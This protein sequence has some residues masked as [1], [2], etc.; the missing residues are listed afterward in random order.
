M[1]KNL[2]TTVPIPLALALLLTCF[3]LFIFRPSGWTQKNGNI[4]Y[5]LK[6]GH[7]AIGWQTIENQ[8]YCFGPDGALLTGWQ[9]IEYKKYYLHPDGTPTTGWLTDQD[10]RRYFDENGAMLVG[11]HT[12]DGETHHFAPDGIEVYLVNPWNKLPKDYTVELTSLSH[13]HQIATLCYDDLKQMFADCK[14]AG[15]SPAICSSYRSQ[16]KQEALFQRKMEQYLRQ[17]HSQQEAAQLAGKVVAVPGTSEHQLGLA[18]DIVDQQNW[19]L[20]QSQENTPTQRWLLENSWKYGFILRYPNAK[21]QIT[22]I[23]Y[24]PW[25]YRYVGRKIAAEIHDSGLCLEEYLGAATA[26]SKP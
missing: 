16:Q 17:G 1:K 25:H 13:G 21:S 3:L 5:Y 14:A 8:R 19:N 20:D 24:E 22:G 9:T 6:N 15:A 4:Y 10:G 11:E 2:R 23:I 26:Q 7:K 12:I 18:L